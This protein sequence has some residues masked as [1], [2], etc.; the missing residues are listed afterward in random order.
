[1]KRLARRALIALVFLAVLVYGAWYWLLRSEWLREKLRERAIQEIEKA[2]G[3]K[4]ELGRLDFDPSLLGASF[5]RFVLHGTEPAGETPLVAAERIRVNLKILSFFKPNVDVGRIEI[6]KP[7]VNIIIG[8]DGK[9]NLPSPAVRRPPSGRTPVE[10]V[11]RLAADSFALA[12]PSSPMMRRFTSSPSVDAIL[13]ANFDYDTNGPVYKGSV[14]SDAIEVQAGKLPLLPVDMAVTMTVEKNAMQFASIRLVSDASTVTGTGRIE[15]FRAMHGEF[16]LKVD[17]NLTES[18]RLFRA[19]PE[20]ARCIRKGDL[21]GSAARA[22][23]MKGTCGRPRSMLRL[24]AFA[25]GRWP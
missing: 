8:P 11:L 13:Q 21:P 24:A 2:T 12:M 17:S 20:R 22:F 6:V 23:A 10:Q 9:S 4:T 18:A 16:E 15:D 1:M 25:F 19:P 7:K 3:G 14:T 5:D